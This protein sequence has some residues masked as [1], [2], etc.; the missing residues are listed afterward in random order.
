MAKAFTTY[1]LINGKEPLLRRIV[2]EVRYR[3]GYLYL[4]HCGRLLKKLIQSPEWV[5]GD[6]GTKGTTVFHMTTAAALSFSHQGA[7]LQIDKSSVDEVIDTTEVE[8]YIALA[9]QTLGFVFDELEVK[10]WSRIGYREHYYFPSDTKEETEAW[11]AR[12]GAHTASAGLAGAFN[13]RVDAAAFSVVLE[14]E[15]CSYRIGLTGIERSAQVPIGDNML[16][17]RS[18]GLPKKQKEALKAVLKKQRQRQV[19][20]AFA[21]VLDMDAYCTDPIEPDVAGFIRVCNSNN[22]ERFRSVCA[23]NGKKGK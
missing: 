2:C 16:T 19:N 13:A 15:D 23:A 7:S 3:D 6:A 8:E 18:S 1:H 10:E 11:L 17:I 20:S 4:D 12:L 9:D 5:V 14:G 22:L 21:A